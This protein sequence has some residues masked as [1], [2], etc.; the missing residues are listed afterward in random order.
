MAQAFLETGENRLII[1]PFQID[2]AIGRQA[3]L[4][5]RRREE[6]GAREAPE[7]LALGPR[8]DAGGEEGG[9]RPVDRAVAAA[10]DFMESALGQ[11][12]ARQARVQGGDSEGERRLGM[13]VSPTDRDGRAGSRWRTTAPQPFKVRVSAVGTPFGAV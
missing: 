9:G 10:G 8:G 5:E 6:V 1:V 4:G 2:D 11:A 7:N 3:G 13:P 12:S